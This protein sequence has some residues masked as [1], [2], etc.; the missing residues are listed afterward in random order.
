MYKTSTRERSFSTNKFSPW[1]ISMVEFLEALESN[2]VVTLPTTAI[3][4][5]NHTPIQESM[6]N[7]TPKS[8]KTVGHAN[9]LT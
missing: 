9:G 8:P 7:T 2:L 6:R 4:I 3:S 1:S 5:R